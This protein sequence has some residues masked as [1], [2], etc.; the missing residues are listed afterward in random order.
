VLDNSSS[1]ID[2]N[3]RRIQE[4]GLEERVDYEETDLF[5]WRPQARYNAVFLSFWISH[6]PSAVLDDFLLLMASALRPGGYLTILEAQQSGT[7]R[8][9]AQGTYRLDEE[10]ERRTLNDGRTFRVVK[11]Y[12]TCEDLLERLRRAGLEAQVGTSG[13]HFLYALAFRPN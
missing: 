11:R 9:P 4:A 13:E 3:R 8:S 5:G 2:L 1:M 12:D 10:I 7:L 6:L